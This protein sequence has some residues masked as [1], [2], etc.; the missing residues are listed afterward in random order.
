MPVK[1]ASAPS[2]TVTSASS[3]EIGDE[4]LTPASTRLQSTSSA[5]ASTSS[6][7]TDYHVWREDEVKALSELRQ[8]REKEFLIAKDHKMLWQEIA[9]VIIA[10]GINVDWQK[11]LNKWKSLKREYKKC[12]DTSTTTCPLYTEFTNMYGLNAGVKPKAI[13]N[14]NEHIAQNDDSEKKKTHQPQHPH[15]KKKR[16][17]RRQQHQCCNGYKIIRQNAKSVKTKE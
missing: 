13:L 6:A 7:G 17:E 14:T 1:V 11:C 9:V 16:K 4:M 10:K 3:P 12:V 15:L 2:D 8:E 5:V